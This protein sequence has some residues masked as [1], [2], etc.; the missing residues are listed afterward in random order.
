MCR[1]RCTQTCFQICCCCR[2]GLRVSYFAFVMNSCH[3]TISYTWY[4]SC[5]FFLDE[6]IPSAFSITVKSR[7]ARH[8]THI[9][10]CIRLWTIL[11]IL[12]ILLLGYSE[13]KIHGKCRWLL[14][15]LGDYTLQWLTSETQCKGQ[16]VVRHG[17]KHHDP[18]RTAAGRS[19]CP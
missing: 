5:G 19:R 8:P 1:R 13:G 3:A 14:Q 6:H 15:W 7:T 9:V 17:R 4:V 2:I 16:G 10:A 12:S 18:A 11:S